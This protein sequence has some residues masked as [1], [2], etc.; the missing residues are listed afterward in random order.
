[1]LGV[2]VLAA[3]SV[4]SGRPKLAVTIA[5][6]LL[7]AI[8]R[9][10]NFSSAARPAQSALIV[11]SNARALGHVLLY[12]QCEFSRHPHDQ[13]GEDVVIVGRPGMFG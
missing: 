2:G 12:R 9:S 7:Q 1:M 3:A 5:L 8:S 6:E 11:E 4:M 13:F 10:V